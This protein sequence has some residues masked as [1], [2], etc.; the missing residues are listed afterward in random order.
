MEID[1]KREE[2]LNYFNLDKNKTT[3][4]VLGGSLGARNINSLIETELDF[5]DTQN[6]QIIWQCGKLYYSQY[7]IYS[8]IYMFIQSL[9]HVYYFTNLIY[10]QFMQFL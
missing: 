1:S 9:K 6:V 2:A 8:N 4:L 7:K 5:L 3:L 10:T